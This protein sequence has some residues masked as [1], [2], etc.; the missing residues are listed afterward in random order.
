[1][2]AGSEEW[3]PGSPTVAYVTGVCESGAAAAGRAISPP[4]TD[5]AGAPPAWLRLSDG[6]RATLAEIGKR[7]GRKVW[8]KVAQVAKPETILRLGPEVVAEKFDGF[9]ASAL[10]RAAK[11]DPAV[12][13]LLCK[14]GAVRTPRLGA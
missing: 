7:L 14:M 8:R 1:M 9:E 3:L 12:E 5:P 10:P 11:I 2:Q 6:E 4:R 13:N